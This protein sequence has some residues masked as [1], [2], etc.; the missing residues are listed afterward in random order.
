MSETDTRKLGSCG[1]GLGLLADS[2]SWLLAICSALLM[3]LLD[4]LCS[5]V[6]LVILLAIPQTRRPALNKN[7]KSGTSEALDEAC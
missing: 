1:R 5:K 6:L 3:C 4:E 7:R 2:Y